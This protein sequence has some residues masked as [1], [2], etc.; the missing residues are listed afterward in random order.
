MER[1]IV[2]LTMIVK[3]RS[4]SQKERGVLADFSIPMILQHYIRY[5][6]YISLGDVSCFCFAI[7]AMVDGRK[8]APGRLES[9]KK[10][11]IK[12]ATLKLT[13]GVKPAILDIKK[14]NASS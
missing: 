5:R 4:V 3:V 10:A 11:R 12:T 8:K 13:A 1:S 2:R 7:A 14:V 6:H 9:I